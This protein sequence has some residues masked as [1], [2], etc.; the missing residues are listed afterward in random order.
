MNTSKQNP[1][2][3]GDALRII[4]G[5]RW[6]IMMCLVVSVTPVAIYN[7]IAKPIFKASALMILENPRHAIDGFGVFQPG[8]SASRTM[9]EIQELKSRSMA[10]AVAKLLPAAVENFYRQNIRHQDEAEFQRKL[11]EDIQKSIRVAPV[12]ESEVIRIEFDSHDAEGAMTVTNLILRIYESRN[13]EMRRKEISGARRE[14]EVQLALYQQELQKSETQLRDYKEFKRIAVLDK[15]S[16]ELLKRLTSAEVLY[17]EVKSNREAARQRLAFIQEK[18]AAQRRDLIPAITKI[19]S[20]S[21][22]KLKEQLVDLDVQYTTLKSQGYEDTHPRMRKLQ[23][24]INQLRA[25]LTADAVKIAKGENM[26]DPISQIH[27]HLE[28]AVSLEVELQSLEARARALREAIAHYESGLSVLPEKE[29]ELARL[30]RAK[31]VN[32]KIY[33]MLLEKREEARIGEAAK[34][35]SVRIIDAARLPEEPYRPRKLFNLIAAV[36][37]G[38]LI[39]GGAAFAMEVTGS[40]VTSPDRIEA[41][42]GN[43]MICAIP[44]VRLSQGSTQVVFEDRLPDVYAAGRRD[45]AS[46]RVAFCEAL[47]T[48]RTTILDLKRE[49]DAD[50]LLITSLAPAEGKSMVAANLAVALAQVGRRVLLVDGDLRRPALHR[51]FS[52]A[53]DPGLSDIMTGVDKTFSHLV[54]SDMPLIINAVFDEGPVNGRRSKEGVF[55]GYTDEPEGQHEPRAMAEMQ[56]AAQLFINDTAYPHVAVLTAG[57]MVTQPGELIESK[58]LPLLLRSLSRQF[59]FVIVDSPPAVGIADA[60]VMCRCVHRIVLIMEN[61]R[62]S[63]KSILWGKRLLESAG[64]PVAGVVLNKI[65]AKADYNPYNYYKYYTQKR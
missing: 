38:L 14:I 58:A 1:L 32:E 61:C 31:N 26:I 8:G 45:N 29:Q 25:T 52:V 28:D 54:T 39:G 40:V 56:E 2:T 48:L 47:R 50:I 49:N 35:G 41:L 64:A 33:I 5:H 22:Q 27:R 20:P 42:I 9:S 3:L 24:E 6:L 17:N 21:L 12:K 57:S 18:I 4:T 23:D 16:E 36:L 60:L 63:Q 51:I 59:D 30:I 7:E 11:A 19:T 13:L 43:K 46:A 65:P 55:A 34:I 37:V 44:Q 53:L 10:E 62:H 15:E